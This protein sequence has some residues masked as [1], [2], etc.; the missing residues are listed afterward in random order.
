MKREINLKN[1]REFENSKVQNSDI[2]ESQSKFYWATNISITK[3][4]NATF[5]TILNK[6][7]LEIGCSDGKDAVSYQ[8]YSSFYTGL[9]ISDQA[10]DKANQRKLKNAQFICSDG[11]KLPFSDGSFEIVIVNSLLHH[12]D[13][14]IVLPEIQRVL[15]DD[16]K[17]IFREPL[18]TNPL[19][20]FYR[21]L[22]PTA[23]TVDERPFTFD[24]LKVMHKYF[25]LNNIQYFGFIT[26]LS[27]FWR[28]DTIRMIL[29]RIDNIIAK[30]PLKYFY[31]QISGVVEVRK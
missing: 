8:T 28:N 18:G 23:R 12:L 22:T 30:S 19:F 31:W 1:E 21:K 29:T 14:S 15:I 27:A 25:I 13:L 11:H 26:I 3:H 2:R 6:N 10:I 4:Q 9:D 16:G 20:N 7:V 24:D 5:D 17:L